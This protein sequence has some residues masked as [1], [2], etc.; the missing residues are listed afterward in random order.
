MLTYIDISAAEAGI[1]NF[2]FYLVSIANGCSI[3]G[4]LSGGLIADKIG[5]STP[6]LLA[7]PLLTSEACAGPLNVMMPATFV[8]GILT[9]AW[10]FA[11]SVASWVVIA[12][13]Y[14]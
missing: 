13:I 6:R 5:E 7:P 8:A 12:V 11:S 2:S 3:I 9:Y 1:S 10:P 14:G 4:R